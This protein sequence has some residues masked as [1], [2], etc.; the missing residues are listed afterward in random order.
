M[1][2]IYCKTI[3]QLP[4]TEKPYEKCEHF[5]PDCLSDAE[6]LSVILRTGSEGLNVLDMSRS[7]LALLGSEG[8]AGLCR[9]TQADLCQIRGI[10]RVKALQIRCIAELSKRIAQADIGYEAD[11]NFNDP[12]TIADY[13]MEDLRHETQEVMYLLCLSSKGS[14]L[15]K[16]I[17]SRGTVNSTVISPREIYVSALSHRAASVILMHNHPSGDPTPSDAD[18][19]VTKKIWKCGN[20]LGITL[21]DHIVVGDHRFVSMKMEGLM[22]YGDRIRTAC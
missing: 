13:Y 21:L 11:L 22:E 5:G 10:G 7:L 14:L 16:E 6:L 4:D 1:K 19:K 20:M 17:I 2:T 9:V 12:Q 8:I 18:I 15:K 3:S